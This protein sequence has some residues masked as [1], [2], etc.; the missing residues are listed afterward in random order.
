MCGARVFYNIA[1]P[2]GYLALAVASLVLCSVP[3]QSHALAEIR[4]V[5]RPGGEVR[6]YEHIRS[7]N[8]KFAR[9][10]RRGEEVPAEGRNGEVALRR[11]HRF[12]TGAG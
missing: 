2:M 3:D 12:E 4:R 8:P 7:H 10:Q 1:F 6:F 5:L 9:R 11:E